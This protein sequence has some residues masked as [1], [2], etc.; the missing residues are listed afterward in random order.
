MADTE[1]ALVLRMEASLAKFEKQMARARK[2]GND[3]ANMLEKRFANANRAMSASAEKSAQVIGREMDRLRTKYDPVYAASKKYEASLTELNKAQQMGAITAKQHEAALEQLNREYQRGAGST[4]P[5]AGTGAQEQARELDMLRA[6]FDPLYAA[7]RRY[8]A[9]LNELQRAHQLGAL[10]VRQYEAALEALN[11]DYARSSGASVALN[12][13]AQQLG[14]GMNGLRGGIQNMSFQVADFAVQVSNGTAA[15]VALGQQLPQLLGG[16]GVMG[17]VMGA[18]VAVGAPLISMLARSGDEAESLEDRLDTL[19]DAVRA[20]RDAVA[21]AR[22]PT[23]DL[24]ERYGKASEKAREFL[25][26]LR[27]ISSVQAREEIDAT[28]GQ[29]GRTY[30]G[31]DSVARGPMQMNQGWTEFS[32]TIEA[33]SK[34]LDV[35]QD[36]ARSLADE[37]QS[38]SEAGSP[39]QQ[40]EAARNMLAALEAALGPYEG[41]NDEAR[42]LYENVRAAGE[43]A[44]NLVG[45]AHAGTAAIASTADEAGRL[46]DEL[47]RALGNLASLQAGA[48]RSLEE[49]EIRLK[50][51]DD[52]VALA[53]ALAELGARDDY[54]T[55]M[56]GATTMADRV[57]AEEQ[58]QSLI[59]TAKA[60]ALNDQELA[61]WRK[62]VAKAA[63]GS[64]GA[65]TL[66]ETLRQAEQI[67]DQTRTKA[68]QYAI[69]LRELEEAYAATNGFE[70]LG[71][72]ETFDRQLAKLQED[73]GELP[74]LARDAS[75]AVRSAFDGVFDEP[76][77]ALENLAK[78]LAQM[79][80]YQ[81]LASALPSVFGAGGVVPLV[82]NAKGGVYSG[83]GINAYSGKVVSTPTVFP[84]AKGAGLMGEAGPE[85]IMPLTRSANG[86]LGVQAQGGGAR[87]V[88]NVMTE[89]GLAVERRQRRGPS[90]EQLIEVKVR[91]TL[92]SGRADGAMRGRFGAKPQGKK[93]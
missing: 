62:E 2:A 6:K 50:Y 26:A 61:E 25:E 5:M 27:E 38:L 12:R 21:D 68:E 67:F 17:A 33:M 28:F 84:F 57:A 53:G 83:A 85:A 70:G 41:M 35:S 86:K 30:G 66:N 19:R 20:Y 39:Q 9:S 40:V 87:Q 34:A 14:S 37:F 69:A 36:K 81:G 92:A 16:F 63:G 18:V 90:G 60:I 32:K 24:A 4:S 58:L 13:G 56:S 91:Q 22:L 45:A 71:G 29:L 11:L 49:S 64:G 93:R 52:P 8:E 55:A 1:T 80:I 23:A 59:D 44:A 47:N 31:F 54:R 73:F 79:A 75:N 43:E 46:A 77:Q 3:S 48:S 15:S 88:V 82:A 74:G 42:A 51:R 10:N 65:K 76:A 72:Q 7:S 78:Q 89:P